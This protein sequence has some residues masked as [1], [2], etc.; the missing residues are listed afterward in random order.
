MA[1]REPYSFKLCM[2]FAWYDIIR[3]SKYWRDC[4]L[5]YEIKGIILEIKHGIFNRGE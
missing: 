4:N 2:K 3:V 5:K 1:C